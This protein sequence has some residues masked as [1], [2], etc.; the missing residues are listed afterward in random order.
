MGPGGMTVLHSQENR[1][2]PAGWGEQR[3]SPLN[4]PALQVNVEKRPRKAHATTAAP[5]GRPEGK[6]KNMVKD[7]GFLDCLLL[8]VSPR[9]SLK[10]K[11]TYMDFTGN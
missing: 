2:R 8:K 9:F 5:Q 3:L 7:K 10:M 1:D 11:C 6:W 4:A